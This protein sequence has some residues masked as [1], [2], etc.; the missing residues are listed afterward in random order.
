MELA[1]RFVIREF[2]YQTAAYRAQCARLWVV[3]WSGEVY[4]YRQGSN[5]MAGRESAYQYGKRKRAYL[6]ELTIGQPD[7]EA[8]RAA[9]AKALA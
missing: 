6:G 2:P 3:G 5:H 7:V 8:A 9:L 1:H 4:P